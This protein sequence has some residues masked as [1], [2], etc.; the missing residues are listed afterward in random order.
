MCGLVVRPGDT[1]VLPIP[2]EAG[3]I[4]PDIVTAL[5]TD[6]QREMPGVKVALIQ[7]IG[8]GAFVY[9]PATG[10]VGEDDYR[11]AHDEADRP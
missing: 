7:G 4:H 8:G 9:R 6:V 3:P 10:K 1:L 2:G 5:R 11:R